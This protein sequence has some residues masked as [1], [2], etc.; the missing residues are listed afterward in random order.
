[1]TNSPYFYG[2]KDQ[3]F[4]TLVIVSITEGIR[5]C[6]ESDIEVMPSL[7]EPFLKNIKRS[8]EEI[9]SWISN[10]PDYEHMKH[11][12]STHKT[13]LDGKK[14]DIDYLTGEVV[15][16]GKPDTTPVNSFFLNEVQKM[17]LLNTKKNKIE[18][19][20]PSLLLEKLEKKVG[21]NYL[22]DLMGH[23]F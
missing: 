18:Y 16:L 10:Q 13:I 5:K 1:M 19:Y 4:R 8:Q 7:I 23:Q 6:Q 17:D 12:V 20:S 9:I 3:A 15:N 22:T 2:F 11:Y 14:S 21:T